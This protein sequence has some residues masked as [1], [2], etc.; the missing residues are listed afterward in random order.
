MLYR[1][2]IFG[3]WLL[4]VQGT[5]DSHSN[6]AAYCEVLRKVIPS[7]VRIPRF[8]YG[9]AGI[10]GFYQSQLDDMVQFPDLRTVVFQAFREVGNAVLFTLHLEQ[11]LVSL[12][13]L[14]LNFTNLFW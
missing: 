9:S 2:I 8:E 14:C 1:Y 3:N 7:I 13:N 4:Q 6:I 10:L 12:I 5:T 11:A